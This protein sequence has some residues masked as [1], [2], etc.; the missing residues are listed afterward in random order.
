MEK[1]KCIECGKEFQAYRTTGN[2][3]RKFCSQECEVEHRTGNKNP[4]KWKGIWKEC[5]ACHKKFYVYPSEIKTKKTCS[6]KCKGIYENMLGIHQKENCNFWH[7]GYDNY[8]GPNWYKQRKLARIRDDNTCQVCGKH[9]KNHKTQMIVHHI[10]PYRFFKNDYEKANDLKNLI[11]LCHNCHAK[12]ESHHWLEV[13]KEYRHLTEGVK[14]QKRVQRTI[15]TNRYTKKEVDFILKNKGKMTYK[16]MGE[17]IGRTE[18]SI[19]SKIYDL[20]RKSR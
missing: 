14:P 2:K 19:T 10:V 6:R 11:T 13:P 15:G 18:Y 3:P 1:F 7:G 20:N 16:E 9:L 17:V 8:K 5:P 12:Q 4:K